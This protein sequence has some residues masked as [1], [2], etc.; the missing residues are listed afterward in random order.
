[1]LPAYR[2]EVLVQLCDSVRDD[3]RDA[4]CCRPLLPQGSAP[5]NKHAAAVLRV[6]HACNQACNR[7]GLTGLHRLLLFRPRAGTQRLPCTCAVAALVTN[8]RWLGPPPPR[9]VCTRP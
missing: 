6:E 1:M 7:A 4:R 2:V 3:E 5:T 8:P 9:A